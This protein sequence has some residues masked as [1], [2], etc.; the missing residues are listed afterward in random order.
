MERLEVRLV[1]DP[2]TFGATVVDP[3]TSHGVLYY[4]HYSFKMSD[5]NRPKMVLRP[6]D[7]YWYEFF[8][9]EVTSIW[10]NAKPWPTTQ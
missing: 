6:A 8:N 10:N 5:A 4:W 1:E 7:G 9:E 3:K 2:L